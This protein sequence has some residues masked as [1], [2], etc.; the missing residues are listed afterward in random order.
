M[1]KVEENDYPRPKSKKVAD[2]LDFIPK[3]LLLFRNF[4]IFANKNTRL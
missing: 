1:R 4:I 2:F 3:K